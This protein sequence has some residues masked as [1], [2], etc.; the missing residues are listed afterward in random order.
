MN[1]YDLAEKVEHTFLKTEFDLKI[2][3]LL[4]EH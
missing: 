2:I 4:L 1:F 3:M